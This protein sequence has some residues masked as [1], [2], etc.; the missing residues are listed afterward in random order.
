[1]YKQFKYLAV[2]RQ[3]YIAQNGSNS[4][5]DDQNRQRVAMKL[6]AVSIVREIDPLRVSRHCTNDIVYQTA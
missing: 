2:N 3:S 1:M 4:I 6:T 5:S